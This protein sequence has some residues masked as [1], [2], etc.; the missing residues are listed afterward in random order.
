LSFAIETLHLLVPLDQ[1]HVSY[2][3]TAVDLLIFA[4]VTA[5]RCADSDASDAK[6]T[7]ALAFSLASSLVIQEA[8][9]RFPTEHWFFTPGTVTG[10]LDMSNTATAHQLL[11]FAV[12]TVALLAHN[13]RNIESATVSTFA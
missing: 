9:Q 2:A 8:M 11:S 12:F 3:A 1:M 6:I 7:A 4:I 5:L 13:T 10:L